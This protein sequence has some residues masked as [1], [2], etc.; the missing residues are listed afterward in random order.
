[1]KRIFKLLFF[2]FGWI[3]LI[4][5]LAFVVVSSTRDVAIETSA[6]ET[7]LELLWIGGTTFFGLGALILAEPADQ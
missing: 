6:V 1:M 3:G 5:N 4:L 7:V 2:A